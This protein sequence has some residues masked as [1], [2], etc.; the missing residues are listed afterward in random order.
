MRLVPIVLALALVAACAGAA[1][2]DDGAT[3]S[4]TGTSLA[5][6]DGTIGPTG[7]TSIPDP[8]RAR[9]PVPLPLIGFDGA[10]VT[11]YSKQ[12]TD[13]AFHQ[14]VRGLAPKVIRVFGGRT[15]NYWDWRAGRLVDRPELP[16]DLKAARGAM[17]PVTL[18]DWGKLLNAS[19]ATGLFNLNM[20]TASLDD[21]IAMLNAAEFLGIN[22]RY[23]ELGHELYGSDPAYVRAFPTGADYGREA[24]RWIE[25]LKKEFRGVR[26][27]VVGAD[28][29]ADAKAGD[30][31]TSWNEGMS[32]TLRGASAITFHPYWSGGVT[33]DATLDDPAVATA[34]VAS[35]LARWREVAK[36]LNAKVLP[37]GVDAWFTELNLS[38]HVAKVHASW[39]QAL[40][41]MVFVLNAVAHPRVGMV[42]SHSLVGSGEFAALY[43]GE[44]D[45]VFNPPGNAPGKGAPAGVPR[46]PT[47]VP[48]KPL[49]LT[50]PGRAWQMVLTAIPMTAATANAKGPTALR[51]EPANGLVAA[52]FERDGKVAIVV[53]NRTSALVSFTVP[54]GLRDV[55][56]GAVSAPPA[57]VA[58]ATHP[59]EIQPV[60]GE[61]SVPVDGFTLLVITASR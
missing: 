18:G 45:L 29:G 26:V 24:T 35:G 25:R 46:P 36:Y 56:A 37:S 47:V 27:G 6:T 32:S 9:S 3:S 19:G 22:V 53:V 16:D 41:E 5:A 1:E 49:E 15:A 55:R 23:V 52:Q 34:V 43:G 39:A 51:L 61:T 8:E 11:T 14:A 38:D 13:P 12:F 44:N 17:T 21:Q 59:L 50:A 7:G 28:P 58:D 33:K 2:R 31:V 42:V 48:T 40:S 4:T 20:V 30:R 54:E 10:D 60:A 57:F